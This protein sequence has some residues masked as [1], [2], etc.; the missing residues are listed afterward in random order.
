MQT[1]S[2]RLFQASLLGIGLLLSACGGGGTGA[3]SLSTV[4]PSAGGGASAR[5]PVASGRQV[6]APLHGV[7]VDDVSGLSSITES[8]SR[9]SR[10]PTTR[11]VFDE[12]QSAASYR[13]ATEAIHEVSYV[14][15]EIL[16]SQ[17]LTT[18]DVKGYLDRTREY[19]AAL[20]DV[21][22]IWE[23]GNEINGEW[24]GSNAD[25]VAK[26][27]GAYD[28]A[29]GQGR[30]T[31]LTLYYNEDCWE[32]RSNEMFTWAQANVP[33]RM[34]QGL[35]YVL[36]SYYEED[37]NNLKPDWNAVFTKLAAMFPHARLGFG[38]VGTSDPDA[39]AAYL[40]RYYALKPAVANY[41]GG[42]FWWYFRQ[43]MVPATKP[44]WRTLDEAIAAT[45]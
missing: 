13:K 39:K 6:P 38:E 42:Y 20:G 2:L 23:I 16:D 22:D 27:T 18:V 44:L 15:G 40:R 11:I 7:T 24:M 10:T 41:V 32:K 30:T 31:A 26:M 1:R 4:P 29:K 43:D 8:L 28:I 9:L 33:E 36:V 14:M 35:D 3:A 25:V 5:P 21:V 19:L 37:C 12:Y 45:H 17:Y 34:K